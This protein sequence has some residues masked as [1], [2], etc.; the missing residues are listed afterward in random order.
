MAS[1][2]IGGVEI[3]VALLT[4]LRT[5]VGSRSPVQPI[6]A[7]TTSRTLQDLADQVAPPHPVDPARRQDP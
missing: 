7:G 5:D 2:L 4:V 1:L 6:F 3:F